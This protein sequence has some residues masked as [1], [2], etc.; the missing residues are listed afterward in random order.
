MEAIQLNILTQKA[1]PR[2]NILN[3]FLWRKKHRLKTQKLTGEC[4]QQNWEKI[5][6]KNRGTS[7]VHTF[8]KYNS[9]AS[10]AKARTKIQGKVMEK[11]FSKKQA[12]LDLD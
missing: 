8:L 6:F 1:K 4:Q 2:T 12:N 5:K 11:T 3:D 9:K 10:I 7:I